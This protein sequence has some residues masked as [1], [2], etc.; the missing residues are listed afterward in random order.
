MN[1]YVGNLSPET[2]EWQVRDA[3]SRYGQVGKISMDNRPR[4][5]GSY[6]FC[7]VEMPLEAQAFRAI[8]KLNGETIGGNILSIKESAVGM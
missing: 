3:F 2:P 5:A 1:I 6:I 7:F 8:T 4:R